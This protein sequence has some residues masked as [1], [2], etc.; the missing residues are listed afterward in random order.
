MTVKKMMLTSRRIHQYVQHTVKKCKLNTSHALRDVL[1]NPRAAPRAASRA[2][3]VPET[4]IKNHVL[5]LGVP[6]LRLT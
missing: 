2:A 1:I 5:F 3:Q 6:K 4:W